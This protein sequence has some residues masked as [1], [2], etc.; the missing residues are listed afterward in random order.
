MWKWPASK[1][2]MGQPWR[3]TRGVLLPVRDGS[4]F[5]IGKRRHHRLEA[6]LA[7]LVGNQRPGDRAD[8]RTVDQREYGI[9]E[10]LL[11]AVETQRGKRRPCGMLDSATLCR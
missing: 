11:G 3:E 5:D 2:R 10:E 9:H 4:A 1:V 8:Q 7:Q 6:T